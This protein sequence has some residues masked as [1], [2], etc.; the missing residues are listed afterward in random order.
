MDP[1]NL[2]LKPLIT[3]K[4][5][6]EAI[7]TVDE[8]LPEDVLLMPS[9]RAPG[10]P[11]AAPSER[12][13]ISDSYFSELLSSSVERLNKEPELLKGE[14]ETI[15]RQVTEAAVEHFSAFV[16]S[17]DCL[18]DMESELE[19]LQGH[20]SSLD[21]GILKFGES[22]GTFREG[23][24][25]IL[26][27]RS[28]VQKVLG[29]LQSI[30][31]LLEIPQ[32]MD[33]CV[34]NGNFDEALDFQ[35]FVHRLGALYGDMEVVKTL[36]KEVKGVTNLMLRQLMNK[37]RSN[38]QLPEC[39]GVIGYLRRLAQFSERDLRIGFLGC[40]E[41]WIAGLVADV[42]NSDPYDYL[43][44]LTDVHRL[45]MFDVVMQYRAVFSDDSAS[46]DGNL[47]PSWALPR[48]GFYLEC[49]RKYLPQVGEGS[50]IASILEH[51]MYCGMSLGRVGLDFRGLLPPVFEPCML[52][53]FSRKMLTAVE[54]SGSA[55]DEH[56]WVSLTSPLASR[57]QPK[58]EADATVGGES[59]AQPPSSLVD[60]LPVATFVNGALTALNELRYCAPASLKV[61]VARLM[62][63]SLA[64]VATQFVQYPI[65]R[66]LDES[67]RQNFAMACKAYMEIA[68]PFLCNSLDKLYNGASKSID[69]SK[70]MEPLAAL[71]ESYT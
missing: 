61:P 67:Q 57:A 31:G 48:I 6:A 68:S 55:L 30:I 5:P 2:K 36:V 58:A 37:L 59:D 45:H 16:G 35:L 1:A 21:V 29:Q 43:K 28:D 51:C 71:I 66:G 4:A 49:L 46:G 19:L 64:A 70:A 11:T 33:A 22:C 42:D 52:D 18:Q 7:G 23:A 60:H 54:T 63:E 38:I 44:K 15:R 69:V 27:R 3:S 34:R 12:A 9:L 17:A 65:I 62:Q 53:L 14:Q 32:L 10:S 13:T 8:S 40:R 39:L 50:N 26:N 25:E 41:E 47:L 24:K 56:K 20:L